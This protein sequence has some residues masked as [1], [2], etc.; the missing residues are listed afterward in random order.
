MGL[1]Y[2]RVASNLEGAISKGVYPI[3]SRLPSIRRTSERKQVSIAT[4]IEAPN[5]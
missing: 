2:E 3:G 4:V 5:G 1:L